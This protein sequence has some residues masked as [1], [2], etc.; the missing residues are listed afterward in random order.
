M[1]AARYTVVAVDISADKLAM[2][3]RLGAD[4]TVNAAEEDPVQA[5]QRLGGAHAAIALAVAPQAFEQAF[6]SLRRKGT[7][8]FVA[9]PA[10]NAVSL[11][12]FETVLQGIT[13]VGSIVGR[14]SPPQA[15][16]RCLRVG[17]ASRAMPTPVA[18][19]SPPLCLPRQS[20]MRSD[21]ATPKATD[22]PAHHRWAAPPGQGH[23]GEPA[24]HTCRQHDRHG[25]DAPAQLDGAARGE[26]DRPHIRIGRSPQTRPRGCGDC[27]RPPP[28]SP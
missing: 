13:V 22:E 4:Y 28:R 14:A 5:I 19:G 3:K 17:A 10:D 8:V 25:V 7:L 11:P 1:T 26:P 20:S 24:G 6:G 9:L 21:T 18:G 15:G 12:I 27:Q 16:G 23:A 2:A